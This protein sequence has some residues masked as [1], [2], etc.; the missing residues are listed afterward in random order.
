MEQK[1]CQSCAM[2]LTNEDGKGT[3]KD[4]SKSEEYCIYCFKNGEFVENL[5]LREAIAKSAD[6]A[7]MA[8]ITKEQAIAYSSK[9]FPTLRRWQNR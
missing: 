4:G 3:N 1:I 2:P 7:D 8:G 9:V 5:T 6:Y